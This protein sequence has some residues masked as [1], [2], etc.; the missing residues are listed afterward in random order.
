MSYATLH[1]RA[2]YHRVPRD[3]FGRVVAA[4][5]AAHSLDSAAL[6][7]ERGP[8]ASRARWTAMALFRRAGYSYP[9]IG[10]VF[11]R[12]HSSVSLGVR[13]IEREDPAGVDRLAASVRTPTRRETAD[14]AVVARVAREGEVRAAAAIDAAERPFDRAVAR[15]DRALSEIMLQAKAPQ[16]PA[17]TATLRHRAGDLVLSGVA[18]LKRLGCL[19]DLAEYLP[20]EGTCQNSC[21]DSSI[22]SA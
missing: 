12:D 20:K 10:A 21:C 7:H 19:E 5:A 16:D 4:V 6:L 13:R 17:D 2:A 15:L 3:E 22:T 1:G 8:D 11:S 18:I 9:Q 14:I